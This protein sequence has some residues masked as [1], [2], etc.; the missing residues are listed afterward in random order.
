MKKGQF[1]FL[2]KVKWYNEKFLIVEIYFSQSV[3]SELSVSGSV[4]LNVASN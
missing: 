1:W 3:L 4:D 2:K